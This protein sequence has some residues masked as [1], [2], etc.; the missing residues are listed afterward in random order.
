M[1][2][3]LA[4]FEGVWQIERRV[5]EA[6]GAEARF[7]GSARFAPDGEGLTY[8]ETGELRLAGQ[9][10]VRAERR[11]L[12][13]PA[14]E[15]AIDVLFADGRPF[16]R[17]APGVPDPSDRHLCSPDLYEVCY[18]F[19]RWPEWSAVWRVTGPRKNYWMVSD[20]RR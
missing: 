19:G 14:P 15:G 2:L 8:A 16:H 18:G 10:P 7:R 4:D 5:V 17:I 1:G 20:Y 3:S 6:G 11:Y 13:R 12:W 9:A